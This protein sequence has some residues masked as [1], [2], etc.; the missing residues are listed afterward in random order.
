MFEESALSG[1]QALPLPH[2]DIAYAPA[3]LPPAQADALFSALVHA[4]PWQQPQ[5]FIHGRQLPTPRLCCWM[6]DPGAAYRYSNTRFMPEPW[7]APVSRLKTAVE[8]LAGTVFNSVLLN[9]Y[10]DG[11][12]AMGWHSDDEPELG[13]NPVIASVSLGGVRRF[14]FGPRA[15]GKS[16]GIELAHG[17]LL[18]M[19]GETQKN[20]RHSLPRTAKQVDGRI[21]LT[22]RNIRTSARAE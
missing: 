2:A 12:D 22:F 5:L 18:L 16:S 14:L 8:T 3:F 15:G 17:S 7:I 13:P 10:R 20:Y 9:Y 11:R 4:V 6:G 1:L 21:N 19:R